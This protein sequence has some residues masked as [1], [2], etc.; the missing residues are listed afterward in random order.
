MYSLDEVNYQIEMIKHALIT[1][2]EPS[3]QARDTLRYKCQLTLEALS[4]ELRLQHMADKYI[5]KYNDVSVS[6]LI[7]SS[8]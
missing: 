6:L 2:Q 1:R 3:E 8:T 7:R 4:Q 5:L